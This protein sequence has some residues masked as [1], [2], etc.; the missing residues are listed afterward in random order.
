M[1]AIAAII[2]AGGTGSRMG[3]DLPKQ[4]RQLN[5]KPVI[6]YCVQAFSQHADI[7]SIVIVH[8][9]E[10]EAY[11]QPI[12]AE[13]QH[14]KTVIGG[15][16]RQ[17][18]VKN[19]LK[20]LEAFGTI[21]KVLIHDAARPNLSHSLIDR[22]V[23]Q[24][25]LAVLPVLAVTD[26]IRHKEQGIV[27]RDKLMAAQ[28]PQ[29]FDFETILALHRQTT[30]Q[31]TDDIALAEAANIEVRYV[32]GESANRKITTEE[33]LAMMQQPQIRVG[34]GYDVHG[35]EPHKAD[36]KTIKICGVSVPCEMAIAGH[37]DGDVGLHAL[38][39]AILGA[40]C[41]GDIGEHFSSDDA[42]WKDADSVVFLEE[43]MR[44]LKEAGGKI[45]H[46]DITL[47]A[48]MPKLS[49]HRNAM[50]KQIA[51]LCNL[52]LNN[53]SVKATTTD[54][55]GFIGRKEGLAAQAT[56]TVELC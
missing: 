42:Q 44:L 1:S 47:V 11:L 4:Y 29:A 7:D 23:S 8:H 40:L 39:D 36:D 55:L 43:A 14:I 2:V 27:E 49:P 33:D 13:F 53:V 35:F 31:V 38:T 22:L 25:A 21:E 30:Q 54:Y 3:G 41:N 37:S 46:A 10:H 52:S 15:Q 6:W 20:A 9:A 16:T 19:G 51:Q 5:G 28:T 24:D 34:S 50:R 18:S 32:E 26:T 12:T 17:Q 56:V 45:L 48:Q